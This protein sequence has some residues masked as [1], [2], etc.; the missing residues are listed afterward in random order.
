[1]HWSELA[2]TTVHDRDTSPRLSALALRPIGSCAREL[3][4]SPMAV[5]ITWRTGT[6]YPCT[7]HDVF[8]DQFP[9]MVQSREARVDYFASWHVYC[10]LHE[11]E[12]YT[13]I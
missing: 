9:A 4:I 3:N 7:R 2:S 11:D 1:M 12:K 8:A 5:R 6:T 10:N 13:C